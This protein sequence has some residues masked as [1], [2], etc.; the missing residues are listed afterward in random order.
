[1]QDEILFCP[2]YSGSS[3]NTILISY[4]ET[5]ILIDAGVSFKKVDIALKK[6]G[7][8]K[9]I[10][11]ILLSHDH[12]DHT[13]CC[14]VYHRKLN[15]PIYTNFKTW[16]YI[17][18]FSGKIDQNQVNIIETGS[19]FSIGSIGIKTFSI[20]HDAFDP[21]G[22][23]FFLGDKKVSIATDMGHIHKNVVREIDNSDIILLESNHDVNMLLSGPYPYFLKQR[24]KGDKGHL[25][26]EQAAQFILD[27]NLSKV[28]RIYLGHLSEENN[29]PSLAMVT[30]RSILNENGVFDSFNFDMQIAD[31]YEPS[32]C[33][34]F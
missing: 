12:S 20:P 10:D 1:M 30:V 5:S 28:K 19:E 16:E 11:A 21:V 8:N 9:K 13:K 6:I 7:F 33:S 4:K 27:L 34:I 29:H 31:R 25:S 23:S 17:K 3:G 22:F 32:L 18:N 24:I 15:I 2:L 14:G 26:N